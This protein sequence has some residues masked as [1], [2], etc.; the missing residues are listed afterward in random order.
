M[1]SGLLSVHF[2][3]NCAFHWSKL[4]QEIGGLLS[5]TLCM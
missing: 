3:I 2:G 4:L 5:H 1:A